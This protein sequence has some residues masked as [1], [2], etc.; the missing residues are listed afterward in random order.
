MANYCLDILNAEEE[1]AGRPKI[2]EVLPVDDLTQLPSPESLKYKILLKGTGAK[3]VCK[4]SVAAAA[5]GGAER[6]QDGDD[7][8]DGEAKPA[9]SAVAVAAG[10]EVGGASAKKPASVHMEGDLQ[11]LIFMNSIKFKGLPVDGDLSQFVP[12]EMVS[13][14]ELSINKHIDKSPV[15]LSLFTSFCHLFFPFRSKSLLVSGPLLCCLFEFT[16]FYVPIN[17]SAMLVV[18]TLSSIVRVHEYYTQ[19]HTRARA[20]RIHAFTH[21]HTHTR[22]RAWYKSP[23]AGSTDPNAYESALA[24]IPASLAHCI[25]QL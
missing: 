2:M 17:V 14:S 13:F 9:T 10:G 11:A 7:D 5:A 25:R 19:T 6:K 20:I 1:K 4:D 24:D 12:Q 21:T 8:D 18:L 15:S 22:A 3:K 23:H 16:C